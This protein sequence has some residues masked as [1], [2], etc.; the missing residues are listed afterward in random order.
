MLSLFGVRVLGITALAAGVPLAPAAKVGVQST[1]CPRDAI[2]IEPGASIE[3]A[4]AAAAVGAVFCLKN[5]IHRAQ[6][7]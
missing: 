7:V 4:V 6:A 5:G 1:S 2:A 3:A